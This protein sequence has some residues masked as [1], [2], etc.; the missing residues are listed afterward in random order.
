VGDDERTRKPP[1]EGKVQT[2]W[3]RLSRETGLPLAR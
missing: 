1:E 2:A 3:A